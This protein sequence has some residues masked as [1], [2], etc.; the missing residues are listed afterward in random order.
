MVKISADR[1]WYSL[2]AFGLFLG[3]VPAVFAQGPPQP[4]G[5]SVV[6]TGHCQGHESEPGCVLPNLFGPNGL[7]LNP[8]AVPRHYAHFIGSAQQT[9]NQTLGTAIAT[10]LALLPIISPASGFTYKYDRTAGAFER[11]TTTFGPIYTERAETIGEGKFYFGVS[12]QRFRFD[13]LD[14]INLKKVPS[15]FAHVPIAGQPYEKD[16]IQATNST[17]LN[18]DQTM[19]FGTVGVTN[20]FDVSLA[21]PIVS[22]R[23]DAS[24]DATIIRVSGPIVTLNDGSMIKNPHAFT[25]DGSLTAV[26]SGK[27]SASGVGDV[28]IRV[29]ESLIDNEKFRVALAM[30]YRIPTG[31]AR[32][33]LGSGSTGIKPFVA[34]STGKRVSPHL[35]LG[36]QWNSRSILA[37]NLTG[38]T[39]SEN[40]S[41]QAT[42]QN[43]AA[44][45][46]HVPSDFFIST[47]VDVGVTNR[48]TLAFDYLGQTVFNAPRVFTKV[49]PTADIKGGT[50]TLNLP[51]ITG[52]NETMTLKSGA[53]GLKLNL[54]GGL[55]LTA[56]VL[57]RMDDN[58]LRQDVTPLIGLSRSFGK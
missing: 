32:E 50:G 35:N 42:I 47:G 44:T 26:Y 12:Y 25:A 41:G 13:N 30:D 36:Y 56:D 7:T 17:T 48:L 51:D 49:T 46:G 21:V 15:V 22:V 33:L 28:T 4:L 20:R 8:F 58:G 10:Q 53:A 1:G 6:V 16:V 18:M 43:G 52:R 34:I 5:R 23:M 38:A 9:L 3:T 2:L 19:F 40:A 57:F 39:F 27:G 31:N 29:K 37:G 45:T 55:L 14:G 24:S 11:S 54:F